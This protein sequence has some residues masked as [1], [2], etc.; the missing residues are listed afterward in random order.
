[1]AGRR[2]ISTD[3]LERLTALGPDRHP[4]EAREWRSWSTGA[5]PFK[6]IGQAALRRF[7]YEVDRATIS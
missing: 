2:W 3:P 6:V 4:Q 5:S 1:V 7:A